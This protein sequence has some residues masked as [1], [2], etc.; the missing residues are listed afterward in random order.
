[1]R[2]TRLILSQH[3][4]MSLQNGQH[5]QQQI[6]KIHGV[7]CQ[8]PGLIVRIDFPYAAIC[9]ISGLGRPH[10]IRCQATVFPTRDNTAQHAGRPPLGIEIFGLEHLLQQPCLVINIENCKIRLQADKISMPT[11]HP[12]RQR[13][14]CAEPHLLGHRAN[15]IRHP[16]FHFTGGLVGEC[17]RQ[18][19]PWLRRIGRHK[20]SQTRSQ[21]AGFAGTCARQHQ[22]RPVQ[23]LDSFLLRGIEAIKPGAIGK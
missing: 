23:R 18:N 17:H 11:Q 22:H 10:L 13:M 19:V 14:K 21:H 12:R 6:T 20:F 9:N 1:M 5:M 4:W 3:V 2:D 15:H 7:Q 8:Q 16:H